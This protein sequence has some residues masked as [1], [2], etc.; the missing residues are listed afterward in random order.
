MHKVQSLE[1]ER[2]SFMRIRS[3]NTRNEFYPAYE[4]V[5]LPD[6]SRHGDRVA[7]RYSDGTRVHWQQNCIIEMLWHP[8]PRSPSEGPLTMIS[9]EQNPHVAS[10]FHARAL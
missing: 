8:R 2:P 3:G 6:E 7:Q 10:E 1:S 4:Q 5:A 9:Q